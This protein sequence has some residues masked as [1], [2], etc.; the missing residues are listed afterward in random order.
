[1]IL[2]LIPFNAQ[3]E[4]DSFLR[5]A[6]IQGIDPAKV[7]RFAFHDYIKEYCASHGIRLLDLTPAL[8]EANKIHPGTLYFK[9]DA[10]WSPAVHAVAAAELFRYLKDQRLLGH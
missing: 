9:T 7:D 2:M 3:V 1:F 10:H 5:D 6:K 8:R 4:D